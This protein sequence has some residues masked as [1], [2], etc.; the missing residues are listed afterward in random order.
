M[1]AH[2]QG[3]LFEGRARTFLALTHAAD[4][5]AAG[6][7][8]ARHPAALQALAGRQAGSVVAGN[9]AALQV[10]E[11]HHREQRQDCENY[12]FFNDFALGGNGNTFF[13]CIPDMSFV[14]SNA[15]L[16]IRALKVSKFS[17]RKFKNFS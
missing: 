7:R 6:A 8:A 15:M 4:A 3:E 14:K 1:T 2:T 12:A 10:V 9:G 5:E 13:F 16:S 11:P 17:I